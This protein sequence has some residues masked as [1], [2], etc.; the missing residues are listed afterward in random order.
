M[1]SKP[2][3]L[4][5]D[6]TQHSILEMVARADGQNVNAAIRDAIDKHI[7]ERRAD[8]D[9]QERLDRIAE[10]NREILERLGR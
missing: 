8:P 3:T 2:L 1:T 10:E 6:E 5:L 7:D 9:F 4:R